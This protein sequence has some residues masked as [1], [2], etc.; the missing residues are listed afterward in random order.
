MGHALIRAASEADWQIYHAIRR[1]VLWEER[2]RG[3]YDEARPEERLHHHHPLLLTFNGQGCGTTRLDDLRDGTGI[4]RGV[5]I[6][7]IL[8]GQGHGRILNA[9]VE[10]YARKL[11]IGTLFVNAAADAE[12]FYAATGWD[13]VESHPLLEHADNCVPM[14]KAIVR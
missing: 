1:S 7:A 14:R 3:G 9:M 4:V 8:R 12:G 2:G 13:R 5:A 10:E 6:S 11:G